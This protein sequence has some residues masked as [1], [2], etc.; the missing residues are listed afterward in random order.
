MKTLKFREQLIA[1]MKK[2]AKFTTWRLFDDKNLQKGERVALVNWEK[3]QKEG[4]ATILS[5]EQKK[6]KDLTEKD[7][8]GHEAFTSEKEL[9]ATYSK[10]YN[11]EID[12]NT[13]LKII[14][15]G[16]FDFQK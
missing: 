13:A 12:S 1:L 14:K 2:G 6:F 9:Y 7:W 5:V 10:Y 4:E 11:K 15:L 16:G 3:G 8:E